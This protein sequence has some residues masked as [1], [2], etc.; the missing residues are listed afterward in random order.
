MVGDGRIE[1]TGSM[2]T[3]DEIRVTDSY[4]SSSPAVSVVPFW[5]SDREEMQLQIKCFAIKLD[6]EPSKIFVWD[7]IR[8]QESE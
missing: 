7:G 2:S 5:N 8:L 6:E 4:S 1:I 3:N